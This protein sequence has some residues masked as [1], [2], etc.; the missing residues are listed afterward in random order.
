MKALGVQEV[1]IFCGCGVP[2]LTTRDAAE[3]YRGQGHHA[4]A[5]RLEQIAGDED[6]R[7][8]ATTRSAAASARGGEATADGVSADDEQA[9]EA[10]EEE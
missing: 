5:D 6:R 3:Y 4:L 9:S 8:S 2:D 1:A 7:A 10:S